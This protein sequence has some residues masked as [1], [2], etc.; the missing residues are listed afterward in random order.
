MPVIMEVPFHIASVPSAK[1]AK[2]AGTFDSTRF[3]GFPSLYS[4]EEEILDGSDKSQN[5]DRD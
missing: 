3:L 1:T 5:F 4:E 2:A